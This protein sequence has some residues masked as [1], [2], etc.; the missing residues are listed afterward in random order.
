MPAL[1]IATHDPGDPDSVVRYCRTLEIIAELR[2]KGGDVIVLANEGDRKA[3]TLSSAIIEI[4]SSNEYSLAILEV[5]P[6]QL[7]ACFFALNSG[8]DP[9]RPR[10][11]SKAVTTHLSKTLR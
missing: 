10:Y 9:D 1:V 6:L 8:I 3:K 2:A 7:L 4:P 11:L 5:L